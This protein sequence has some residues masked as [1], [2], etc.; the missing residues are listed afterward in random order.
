MRT[1]PLPSTRQTTR[2]ER[3]IRAAVNALGYRGALVYEHGHW[4]LLLPDGAI[5]DVVDA[6]GPGSVNGFAL[7]AVS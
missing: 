1:A 5:F 7:E 2:T 6:C 3:R 4:W